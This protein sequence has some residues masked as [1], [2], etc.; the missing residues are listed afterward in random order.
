MA[1]IIVLITLLLLLILG[2]TI[3]E[4][5]ETAG[6][7]NIVETSHNTSH[8][9]HGKALFYGTSINP[10]MEDTLK[11]HGFEIIV[12]TNPT[13]ED[14]SAVTTV[15]INASDL[16]SNRINITSLEAVVRD[17]LIQGKPVAFMDEKGID[18]HLLKS[19]LV[20]ILNDKPV[21]LKNILSK[22]DTVNYEIQYG[23]SGEIVSNKTVQETTY[24]FIL[25][26]L[27]EKRTGVSMYGYHSTEITS[28]PE[29]VY[30]YLAD[31]LE[32]AVEEPN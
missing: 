15:I 12:D 7:I 21:T 29:K 19:L 2:Y 8:N 28:T 27:G 26:L 23:S 14:L 20:K 3:H 31:Y 25:K 11:S 9:Y 6:N 1:R 24:V 22:L 30:E 17:A 18:T 5:L 13:P 16:S 32:K 10:A 4:Q